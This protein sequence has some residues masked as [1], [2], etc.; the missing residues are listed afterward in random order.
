MKQTK[1]Y[2]YLGTNGIID[3]PVHLEGIYFVS[4]IL[5]VADEGKSLTKDGKS[6]VKS[7][8]VANEEEA[9]LWREVEDK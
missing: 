4:S 5:L 3:S 6:L 8:R 1:M 2:R 9:A 7:I